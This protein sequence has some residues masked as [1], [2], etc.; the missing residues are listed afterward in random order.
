MISAR[1][2]TRWMA[3]RLAPG[4]QRRSDLSLT[5]A[6]CLASCSTSKFDELLPPYVGRRFC[7]R[8]SLKEKRLDRAT[9][10][11]GSFERARRRDQAGLLWE[12]RMEMA[13]KRAAAV[14]DVTSSPISFKLQQYP[15]LDNNL[16]PCTDPR[17][18]QQSSSA[19]GGNTFNANRSQSTPST[20]LPV[21]SASSRRYCSH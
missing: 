5:V 21:T 20:A 3:F 15:S 19:A 6:S 9:A 4:R 11:N 14:P 17:R 2:A 13:R 12:S 8:H 18:W 10:V 1:Q 16:P 7:G